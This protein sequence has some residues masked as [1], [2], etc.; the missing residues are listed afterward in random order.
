MVRKRSGMAVRLVVESAFS[1]PR[2]PRVAVFRRLFP[3]R[4]PALAAELHRREQ[5]IS[6]AGR[7]GFRRGAGAS[8]DPGR[9]PDGAAHGT[10]LAG[11]F[12]SCD[13]EPMAPL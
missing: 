7:G 13:A 11:L 8:R 4:E 1:P 9:A 6:A 5:I 3:N 12:Q 2:Y 10:D